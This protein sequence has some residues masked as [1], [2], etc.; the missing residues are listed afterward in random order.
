MGSSGRAVAIALL[1]AIGFSV[2]SLFDGPGPAA[3][4]H[5]VPEPGRLVPPKG[6]VV[7]TGALAS[8]H[9][10]W[11]GKSV[12]MARIPRASLN[13][14]PLLEVDALA[15]TAVILQSQHWWFAN[16]GH[17]RGPFGTRPAATRLLSART[18]GVARDGSGM[19]A[20]VDN[21]RGQVT[22]WDSGGQRLVKAVDLT[23][24][25]HVRLRAVSEVSLDQRRRLI[26][27][28]HG[29]GEGN[30]LGAWLLLRYDST[31]VDTLLQA[32][33][34]NAAGRAFATLSAATLADGSVIAVTAQD[35]ATWWIDPD[36][37]LTRHHLRENAPRWRV[38]T[39]ARA[40][41]ASLLARTPKEIGTSSAF[42][43]PEYLPAVQQIVALGNGCLVVATPAGFS[44]AVYFEVLDTSGQALGRLSDAPMTGHWKLT[45][46][47]IVW[48]REEGTSVVVALQPF[49]LS[50]CHA[51]H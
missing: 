48:R 26:V 41:I 31:S 18:M 4:S 27:T 20:V 25:L 9:A 30:E 44:D 36:G 19:I 3:S 47:G 34:V 23:A 28:A 17:L 11:L 12:E 13:A 24:R 1:I 29:M 38:P 15:D 2:V 39:I 5:A 7:S 32:S 35:V 16:G 43:Q 14:T 45:A 40:R 42:E 49:L 46:A 22:F 10:G 37:R 50:S 6:G 51:P 21:Q 8:Y 33:T